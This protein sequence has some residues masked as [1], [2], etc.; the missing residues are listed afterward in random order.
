MIGS[1]VLK[2]S[3]GGGEEWVVVSCQ[4]PSPTPRTRDI[5]PRPKA[6]PP[7]AKH[8]TWLLLRVALY[9]SQTWNNQMYI[10]TINIEGWRG[11]WGGLVSLCVCVCVCKRV[12]V[13][14]RQRVE[15]EVKLMRPS[16][17]VAGRWKRR[18]GRK[19]GGVMTCKSSNCNS[20]PLEIEARTYILVNSRVDLVRGWAA[21]ILP[22]VSFGQLI[23]ETGMSNAVI[24]R[25]KT[26]PFSVTLDCGYLLSFEDSQDIPLRPF[27]YGW[28]IIGQWPTRKCY[29][30]AR[31]VWGDF[32]RGRL[33][34][35]LILN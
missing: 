6:N 34:L 26:L 29:K 33:L 23:C 20:E 32:L 16:I 28:P 3:P 31:T 9:R 14:E 18:G 11:V 35:S 2:E 24:N 4:N 21:D 15:W 17:N 27:L 1:C 25:W 12:C 8:L 30:T 22:T 5:S 10:K 19:G 7:P 13:N